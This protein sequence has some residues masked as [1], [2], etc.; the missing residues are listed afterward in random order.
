V[1]DRGHE[2]LRDLVRARHAAQR[3]RL[4]ARNR[5][6]KFLLKHGRNPAEGVTAWSRDYM[7][8][9]HTV[10]FDYPALEVTLADYIHEV[11]HADERLKRLEEEV[12]K[13]GEAAPSEIHAVV[14]GLQAL[15]GIAAIS[16]T[17]VV[18]EMG[19][20][21]RF[22]KAKQLMGY[23]GIVSSEH[24]TGERIRRGGITKTGNAHL[25]R[26]VVEAAW[27]YRHRPAIGETLAARQKGLSEEVKETAW[28]AQNRLHSR[29]RKL[30]AQGM[31]KQKVITAIARELLGFIW[32]I[33][34]IVR[35]EQASQQQ[36]KAA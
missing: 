17:T 31:P 20:G 11:A 16:A 14:K 32:D 15:R 12:R 10:R 6:S 5:L 35:R 30:I 23:S 7:R 33:A 29:Y 13:A 19:D 2:A 25:R 28:R 3:D 27:A 24:S 22:G 4:R 8:W 26:I 1:P 9:V 21:S 34:R 36:P 18:A